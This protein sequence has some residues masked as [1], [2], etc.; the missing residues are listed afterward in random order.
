L[1]SSTA[2]SIL[3]EFT[4]FMLIEIS[5]KITS[6]HPENLPPSVSNASTAC[7]TPYSEPRK[8]AVQTQ[9][10][11]GA[12]DEVTNLTNL[13]HTPAFCHCCCCLCGAGRACPMG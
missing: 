12:A 1:F 5:A 2:A 7:L 8:L 13:F 4:F 9:F 6:E 3:L 10:A 11:L